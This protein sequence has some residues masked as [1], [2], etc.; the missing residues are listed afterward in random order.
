MSSCTE[1]LIAQLD[2]LTVD[3]AATE[4]QLHVR[5]FGGGLFVATKAG[6]NAVELIQ[7]FADAATLKPAPWGR[8]ENKPDDDAITLLAGPDEDGG[9]LLRVNL[10]A[11]AEDDSDWQ[12]NGNLSITREAWEAAA[13]Q[14]ATMCRRRVFWGRRWTQY[15]CE[16]MRKAV[17]HVCDRHPDR[18]NCPDCLV[19]YSAK[20]HEYGL[21]I[22]DGGSSSIGIQYC[23][24][25]GAKLPESLR[26]T[27]VAA[28][29]RDGCS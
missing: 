25:C 24:W 14:V 3:L 27:Q 16:A 13:G 26:G 22:H 18:F 11:S 6:L 19:H 17:E 21:I 28:P 23:P 15:C 29:V 4:G 1:V 20:V 10:L 9:I 2:G 7:F 12:A 8:W 5:L